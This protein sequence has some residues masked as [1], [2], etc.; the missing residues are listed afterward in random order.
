MSP[1]SQNR[2]SRSLG[3]RHSY[4]SRRQT[5]KS[6]L[7]SKRLSAW[8]PKLLPRSRLPERS[9]SALQVRLLRRLRP[10]KLT[11]RRSLMPRR[12]PSRRVKLNGHVSKRR[13]PSRS[14]LQGWQHHALKPSTEGLMLRERP[15]E[16]RKPDWRH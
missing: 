2:R 10:P 1:R 5:L 6:R 11:P 9:L 12:Y 14:R 13:P 16:K 7:L 4:S 15:R 3:S 8:Q